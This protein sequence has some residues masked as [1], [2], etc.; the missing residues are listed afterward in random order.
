MDN[1]S[2][3]AIGEYPG[4]WQ[5]PAHPIIVPPD[6]VC[7]QYDV[8]TGFRDRMVANNSWWADSKESGKI[9]GLDYNL[10]AGP[11]GGFS[12]TKAEYLATLKYT[13]DL[14]KNGNR[15]PF[16][17]GAHSQYY[18]DKWNAAPN[19]PSAAD[20]QSVLEDFLDYV[21]QDNYTRVVTIEEIMEWCKAPT[22]L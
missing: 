12:M 19:I 3:E 11:S 9:T 7:D 14:R 22:P 15:S 10:I 1:G 8:A 5:M 6:E 17:F 20:R 2:H 4:L 18:S 16:M 13:Y 21:L